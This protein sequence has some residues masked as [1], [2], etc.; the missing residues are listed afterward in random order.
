VH[1]LIENEFFVIENFNDRKDFFKKAATYQL[2]FN[3]A[4]PNSSKGNRTPW[5]ILVEDLHN[6]HPNIPLLT[7][8]DLDLLLANKDPTKMTQGGNHVRSYPF[9]PR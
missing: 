5:D 4:R 3:V 6:P 8:I 7:P 9:F 2:F 1:N